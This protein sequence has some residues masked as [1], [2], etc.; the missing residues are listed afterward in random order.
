MSK[1]IE[2]WSTYPPP[3]GG[4]SVHSMRL[5]E[6]LKRRISVNQIIFKNFNGPFHDPENQIYK[7]N[8]FLREFVRLIL[9]SKRTIHLHSNNILLWLTFSIFIW[10]HNIIITLHNQKLRN[11]VNLFETF[12]RKIFLEKV[13]FII[14]NDVELANKINKIYHINLLKFQIIPAFIPPLPK[15]ETGLE[16]NFLDFKQKHSFTISTSAWKLYKKDGIDIYGIDQIIEALNSLKIEG[17]SIGLILIIP[18]AEDT[19]YKFELLERIRNYNL[20]NQIMLV[21]KSIPN[22][23]EVWK[24]S[25]LYIRATSTDIEGLTIKEALYYGTPVIA[26]DVVKR[27]D[28][29]ILY[30][31]QN[32]DD[33]KN[34]ILQVMDGNMISKD[35]FNFN[36]TVDEISSLYQSFN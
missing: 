22:A 9:S 11:R 19:G 14:L 20:E 25:D 31:F 1:V 5:F 16:N 24:L 29:C 7:V 10:R 35:A 30:K 13:D 27:P 32:I 26:S 33:L 4:V 12:I 23:F 17:K 34:K 15:E 6:S 3:F 28:N 8:N 18:I 36:N 2:I 21:N